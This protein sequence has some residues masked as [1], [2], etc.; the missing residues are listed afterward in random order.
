MSLTSCFHLVLTSD[1]RPSDS[2]LLYGKA[3]AG[4]SR[5]GLPMLISMLETALGLC[6]ADGGE[7]ARITAAGWM[8]LDYAISNPSVFFAAS[9]KVDPESCAIRLLDWREELLMAGWDGST[10]SLPA[11]RQ[12]DAMKALDHRILETRYPSL[13]DR[14]LAVIKEIRNGHPHGLDT[15]TT[16][17]PHTAPD[18]TP[19]F[20]GLLL[21]LF[22]TL[23]AGGAVLSVQPPL[24]PPDTADDLGGAARKVILDSEFIPAGDG[25]LLKLTG[26]SA[27]ECAEALASYLAHPDNKTPTAVIIAG[28]EERV[29]LTAAFRRYGIAGPG[30]RTMS[31]FRAV[32]QV[33][34]LVLRLQWG[35]LDPEMFLE[36][37]SLPVSPLPR[38]YTRRLAKVFAGKPGL[39]NDNWNQ[40]VQDCLEKAETETEKTVIAGK[41]P[42]QESMREKFGRWLPDTAA[43]VPENGGLPVRRVMEICK[44]VSQWALRRAGVINTDTAQDRIQKKLF[45]AADNQ[46]RALLEAVNASGAESFTRVR[47]DRLL[48]IVLGKTD[49]SADMD[50][51]GGPVFISSPADMAEPADLVVWWNFSEQDMSGRPLFTAQE[52]RA[53]ET[54]GLR[55]VSPGGRAY[56][57]SHGWKY[58]FALCRKKLILALPDQSALPHQL[59][60]ALS[61]GW[62]KQAAEK[63]TAR[64]G[65]LPVN[66]DARLKTDSAA[67]AALP[68]LDTDIAPVLGNL[69]PGLRDTESFTSLDSLCRCPMQYV[70]RYQC[71]LYPAAVTGT[72][73]LQV[74][75]GNAGHRVVQELFG[76]GRVYQDSRELSTLLESALNRVLEQEASVLLG[77]KYRHNKNALLESMKSSALALNRLLLETGL[78][79]TYTERDISGKAG[80]WNINGSIDLYLE[81]NIGCGH[82]LDMKYSSGLKNYREKLENDEAC[83]LALYRMASGA[84]SAGFFLLA[85]GIIVSADSAPVPGSDIVP[86][87]LDEAVDKME[88]KA[89]YILKEWFSRKAVPVTGIMDEDIQIYT[90]PEDAYNPKPYCENCDYGTICGYITARMGA[91]A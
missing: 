32:Q 31:S 6:P 28:P 47:L 59:W 58:P 25:S 51:A 29:E 49:A 70:L 38:K 89:S 60:N 50:M 55:F 64:A 24:Q 37:L 54:A 85:Q 62:D 34:P 72:P 90:P 42:P 30:Y 46:A 73:D 17:H 81:D 40:A 11:G 57:G 66:P 14:I 75:A 26:R 7:L 33:L 61:A 68:P 80:T 12:M 39:G 4:I 45:L 87:S 23:A 83:Q 76:G 74:L 86:G 5:G 19:L 18:V 27:T 21:T 52:T 53:L 3:R 84:V 2:T 67:L 9:V 88:K 22:N 71:G 56:T 36:F 69:K 41:K 43:L 78:R 15:L 10:L 1:G 77:R 44:A 65:L 16:E 13:A 8:L 79:V 35:P 20:P 63:I 48:S 82:I 91:L